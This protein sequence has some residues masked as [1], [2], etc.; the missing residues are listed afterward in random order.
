MT[1]NE[2]LALPKPFSLVVFI[3]KNTK[4]AAAS[5]ELSNGAQD[6]NTKH[7]VGVQSEKTIGI[8]SKYCF[9]S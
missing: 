3:R 4:Q 8:C 5:A 1:F 9:V 7:V 6:E 2:A